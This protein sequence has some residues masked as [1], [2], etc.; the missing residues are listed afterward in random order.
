MRAVRYDRYGLADVLH[1][2]DVAE[3][4]PAAGEVKIRVRAASLNPIDWKARSGHMRLIPLFQ[5]PPRGTGCDV[6]GEI[7]GVGSGAAPRH[8]GERVF[9][10]IST[11]VRDGTCAE[12]AVVAADRV[13]PIPAGV[14]FAH[15]AALPIAGGTALQAL[16]D[17]ARLG[18]DSRVLIIGAAGGV[19]HFAAQIA[20]YLGAYVV[21]VCGAANVE[22]VRGLGA[23]EVIDYARDDYARREDRFDAVFDAASA[24]TF[25]P[26]RRVLTGTG[27]YIS[28]TGTFGAAMDTMVG[29][30]VA[31]FT[32]RQ[33][34]IPFVLK[35]GGATWQRLADLARDRV[36]RPHVERTIGLDQVADAQRS[37]EAG[38]GRGKIV[39]VP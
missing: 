27:C 28:T 39:V 15:A 33:R 4:V 24:S 26:A 7:V 29:A 13:A 32:S 14:D 35:A 10:A 22:F 2:A 23:D 17:V 3:P 25:G 8:A 21:A 19:G 6:A 18:P 34:A 37:M 38:H 30:L 36:L 9:G 31:R 5:G 12:F 11:F 1:V 16:A 20:K